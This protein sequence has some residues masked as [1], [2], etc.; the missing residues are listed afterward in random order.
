MLEPPAASAA[1]APKTVRALNQLVVIHPS[2]VAIE[3][4][5]YAAATYDAAMNWS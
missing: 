3:R 4:F 5:A 2:G 1:V